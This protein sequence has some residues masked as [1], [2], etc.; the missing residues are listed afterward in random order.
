MSPTIIIT[1]MPVLVG[2]TLTALAVLSI[3]W[4]VEQ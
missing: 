2:Y 1:I 4:A 3:L